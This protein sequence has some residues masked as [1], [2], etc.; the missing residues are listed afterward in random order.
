ME[1]YGSNELPNLLHRASG[2]DSSEEIRLYSVCTLG[3]AAWTH[4]VPNA[5]VHL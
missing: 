1:G 5:V 2:Y 3:L 4:G